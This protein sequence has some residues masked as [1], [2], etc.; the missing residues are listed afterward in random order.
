MVKV[1]KILDLMN[2]LG[3]TLAFPYNNPS[4]IMHAVTISDGDKTY[5]LIGVEEDGI[6]SFGRQMF[7]FKL[8]Y[9]NDN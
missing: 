1:N 3:I 9:E 8:V 6:D 7:D 4:E 2:E 5:D